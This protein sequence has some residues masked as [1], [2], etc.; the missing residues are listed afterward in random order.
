MSG[1]ERY[2]PTRA[3]R[4]AVRGRES[5][6]LTALGIHWDGKSSHIRCPYQDHEDQHPSWRWN[7]VKRRAHCT[8]TPS[9]SI[10]DVVVKVRGVD[11]E[12][13]KIAVAEMVGRSDLIRGKKASGKRKGR[14]R[15]SPGDNTATAQHPGCTLAAYAAAKHLPVEF[16]RSLGITEITLSGT[17]AVRIPYLDESGAEAAVRFRVAL[18]DKDRFRWRKGSKAR[19]YGLSRLA[20]ARD[21]GEIALVEGESDCHTLWHAGLAA[22][23][24]PGAGS[25]NENRDAALFDKFGTIYVVI[26]PDKGGDSIRKWLDKSRIRNRAK[27][28]SLAPFKDSSALY[29]DDP[30]RFAERWRAAL[31][32][33]VPWK[34]QAEHEALAAR[35]AA[36]SACKVLAEE[37]DILS[38]AVQVLRNSG[39]VGE[40][41]PIKLVYLVV[42]SRLLDRIVSVAIKGP[43]SGG[44]SFLVEKVLSLFPPEA[45]H[46][47]T[48]MSERALAY[49]N[50]P[51]AHRMVVLYEAAG[52]TGVFG[53]YLV[54]S[55]LSEGRICYETVEKTKDGFKVRRIERE[56]PTGLITTTTAVRLH[57]ENETRLLSLTVTD[58]PQQTK[59][60]MR[61]QAG[62]QGHTNKLNLTPWH[63]L[64]QFLAL[65]AAHVVIPFATE[66]ADLVPAM[67]VRLRR[68]FPT[69]LA[70]IEAHALLH[71]A[72]R[73]RTPEG[74][75][76]ATLEDYSA[77]REIVIDFISQGVDA[78][79][80]KIVRDAVTAVTELATEDGCDGVSLTK[81]AKKLG[82]DKSSTS[83]R[84]NDAIARG[85]LK[86]LEEKKGRSARLVIGDPLPA[87]LEVLPTVATL[88]ERCSVAP[89]QEGI[90][91]SPFPVG[92]DEEEEA[93]TL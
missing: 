65:G 60:I 67:A 37:P 32:D 40:E 42:T 81:L 49:S 61:A 77:V 62:R 36:W 66:L 35:D 22:V 50:E 2:V 59:A 78:T 71:Q 29:L 4:D 10:F 33:A 56:G 30:T 91:P 47:L 38:H 92:H 27:L 12:A 48:G 54:R 44:K 28:V 51:L 57:P 85:Y 74:A 6:V 90:E 11:F 86:N 58:T 20:A 87:D 70:L 52:L 31:A 15:N 80:P 9:A 63:A 5:A 24:L 14:G 82:L 41:R 21:L 72:T 75:V 23:G 83:R 45:A 93:W 89:L 64:Q 18:N 68:D 55:L 43:S 3:I 26:E 46:V 17:P 73:E 19:L 13:A 16:L 53:S 84:A 79:V 76:I 1:G 69:V 34:D 8:C 88:R 39:L 25:W 7:R